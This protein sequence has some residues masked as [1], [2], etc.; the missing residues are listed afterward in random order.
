MKLLQQRFL[1]LDPDEDEK[2]VHKSPKISCFQYDR[3]T[4]QFFYL[5]TITFNCDIYE[6]ES[7]EIYK[8]KSRKGS[9]VCFT[10][11]D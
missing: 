5:I 10:D 1:D 6:F 7:L 11:F 2:Q 9:N 3:V 4:K 8:V